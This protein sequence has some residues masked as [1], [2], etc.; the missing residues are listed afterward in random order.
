[1]L[2]LTLLT[3]LAAP[4]QSPPP[5]PEK[6]ELAVH[7]V[8]AF[9]PPCKVEKVFSTPSAVSVNTENGRVLIMGE[10]VGS[11]TIQIVCTDALPAHSEPAGV[12][13]AVITCPPGTKPDV[14]EKA[15]GER[16]SSCLVEK[17]LSVAVNVLALPPKTRPVVHGT[18][19]PSG[20]NK[21]DPR[22]DAVHWNL[23]FL[24]EAR[25]FW[26]TCAVSKIAASNTPA[27]I[28]PSASGTLIAKTFTEGR[29]VQLAF[30]NDGKRMAV[31]IWVLP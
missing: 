29:T 9:T 17:E 13:K 22:P 28:D 6:L 24:G 12:D 30:C 19:G 5:L 3:L 23:L 26:P 20:T 16:I 1:M 21:D 31:P 7:D 11:G 4:P 18:G 15:T 10:R 27:T 14:Y 8:F 25:V 2:T